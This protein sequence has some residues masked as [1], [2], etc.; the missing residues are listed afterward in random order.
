MTLVIKP[1]SSFLYIAVGGA[2]VLS[3]YALVVGAFG[4]QNENPPFPS[5]NNKLDPTRVKYAKTI[6]TI[7]QFMDVDKAS[8][9]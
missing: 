9:P 5:N 2:L 6:P 3:I 1:L 4:L 7:S 8:L